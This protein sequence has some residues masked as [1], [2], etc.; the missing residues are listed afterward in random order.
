MQP[1]RLLGWFAV[2]TVILAGAALGRSAGLSSGEG[3]Y[4]TALVLAVTGWIAG[5]RVR[6]RKDPR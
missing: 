6:R 3:I 4:L 5:R 1:H 2:L